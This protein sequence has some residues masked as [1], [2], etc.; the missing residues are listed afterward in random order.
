MRSQ[1]SANAVL[2]R[3]ALSSETSHA[4]APIEDELEWAS[5]H[6]DEPIES[7]AFEFADNVEMEPVED[8]TFSEVFSQTTAAYQD[9][10]DQLCRQHIVR[11]HPPW[12]F[13]TRGRN[14]L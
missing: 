4:L 13:L 7:V 6:D 12:W 14:R 8:P 3:E 10:Y 11:R 9:S 2:L 5:D 1:R